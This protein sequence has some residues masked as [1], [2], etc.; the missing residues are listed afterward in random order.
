MLMDSSQADSVVAWE[1]FERIFMDMKT[2]VDLADIRQSEIPDFSGYETIVVLMSDLNPLKDVVI[3]IG[4][5]VEKGGRVLFA[6]TLQKDTYVSLIE[7]KLGITDSDYGNVLVDKIYIDDDFMIGG[8]R[9]FQIPD[10]Y[11]SA[12][13]VSVGETAK[14]YAWTDDEKKVPLIWENSYGK[15]KFVVDNFGL[16]EKAT[17]GFFAASYSLLTDVMVY[18]VLNGSVFYLDDF[19]SPVPSGDGTYI[20]RDYGLSI[21]EFYTNIWWPDMLDMAEEHG[22]KYTGVIIDNYEDDVSGDVVEQEDVQRFQYFGN[23][24]LHQGGELGYHGYNH[25]PLSLSNVDYANILPY[26][27]WESY[28]AMKKAMTE[29]IRFGKEMFPGTELSVYVPPS[30]VL[31]DEG[32]EMIVKEF[33]EI[34]TIASNYFVGDMA[35]TQE[36]EA[37]EDGIVEQPRIISGAV[38]DDYMELAAVSELNMHFVNTHFMHPDDRDEYTIEA[39]NESQQQEGLPFE[40]AVT[41]RKKSVVSEPEEDLPPFQ[42]EKAVRPPSKNPKSSEK[43]I[44]SGIVNIQHEITR[45]EA[46]VKKEYKFPALNL[47]K[48][49]SSKAQGDSDAYLRKTAKKL[50]EVLHNFGVNVTVT[51]VSCGPTV[52]RYELQPEMGV[53]V[54]KIVGL[55]DDIK[56]NL[57]TPDIRIEAP[58]PGKAA[59]GIEVP[60]KENSTVMLRDLLQSEE[61]QKAKSKLSFAVGKDIAGKTVVADIAK[62]PH[63]LIAGATGS[64][65]SVCINTLIISILYKAKPDEV[66][67]IMIDPKVVELSVYNGIPHLFI[68]VVTDPKKAAGALNWA[69]Q[70]MTNRYN[71]FAEYGVRNLDE[72]NRKAEQIKA[73]GA[74]EEPVKMPQIVIIVD[75]LAD[76]MMVAPGEVE[77]AICRLAQLA[78]A[79]G[80]H[81]IIATQRPSVNV[82]TGLI[83]ANMPSRIAFSVS[84]GV[85]SRTILDM[86][87]AEKLLGKGDMLFYPQGY[88]KPA[89][90]QGAFV[91]DDEV[92]AVVEF[93]AD[94]NPGVQYNQQ[95]EQQVN[96]PVTTGMSGD[97]RDIHFEEAGKFIIEKEKASIGMLQRMFKI[98]FNRA[99]RIMDQLCDAGVVGPEEGTKPRKVLMSMEEFQNY[100]ENQ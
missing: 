17:R 26:K 40:D 59:V 84:S 13:E 69:V 14:V 85:D 4:N 62:M 88:Q 22:V 3:K 67:L 50:Q 83:K 11:D 87:G 75:E 5:W 47:L 78:R 21:K 19:P 45:Q 72:Y 96:S 55:A 92:S 10:A 18:P 95:I 27:T 57:A 66:K 20:K 41:D 15:G 8:G 35:Y 80:I 60:N 70:E 9:S 91:S 71:T 7:Q 39:D 24:L 64:G 73:A 97:E 98:G 29:L 90:L 23:M 6:L 65:K 53:K 77:D 16:C 99:A 76:L 33:P 43:E 2:G 100:L 68:P 58:I 46:A 38:I 31:S 54:S 44:Q 82:I 1:Q 51:N 30:N 34:R 93:L 89:R 94:K 25:Q 36:F 86:N 56:L 42:D 37:A 28:D 12:W 74:E 61:F 48:K 32:R 81:L 52:T 63:L 79:A 49:G